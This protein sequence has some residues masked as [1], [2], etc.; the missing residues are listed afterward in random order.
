GLSDAIS[1]VGLVAVMSAPDRRRVVGAGLTW[2]PMGVIGRDVVV[3]EASADGGGPRPV[4][5]AVDQVNAFL[6]GLRVL[7]GVGA[8]ALVEVDDRFHRDL[9]AG[10][11]AGELCERDG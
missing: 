8:D 9:R 7:V 1:G 5:A 11:K 10:E 2:R 4:V 3:V 6:Q